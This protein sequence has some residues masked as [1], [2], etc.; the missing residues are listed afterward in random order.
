[1]LDFDLDEFGVPQ[2]VGLLKTDLALVCQRC[3]ER[4]DY[5]VKIDLSLNWVRSE[6]ELK[7]LP[8]RYEPFLVESIPLRLND[9]IEDELLLALP[10]IAMHDLKDCEA[11]KFVTKDASAEIKKEKPNPFAVLAELKKDN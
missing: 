6:Q 2:V 10:A 7:K 1:V 4:Y 8:L 9:V 3:L 5:P 11:A